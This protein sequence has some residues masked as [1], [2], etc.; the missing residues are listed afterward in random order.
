[1]HII[2]HRYIPLLLFLLRDNIYKIADTVVVVKK[3]KEKSQLVNT[4]HSRVG[5]YIYKHVY[6]MYNIRTLSVIIIY[7]R[8]NLHEKT[9]CLLTKKASK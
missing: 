4:P 5:I 9:M 7:Y 2:K 1:M 8:K 6:I 3:K